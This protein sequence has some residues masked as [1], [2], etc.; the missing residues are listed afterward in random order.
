M[1][2]QRATNVGPS[3]IEIAYERLG[4]PAATPVLLIMGLG[5]QLIG[6]A[7]D[8]CNELVRRGL[9]VIRFDNR[10]VGESTHMH[11]APLP[12]L[13]AAMGGDYSTATYRLTDMAA[14]AVGLLDVLGIESA[15]VVGASMGG[16]I[17]QTMAIEH[18]Q[19]VRSL[20]SIMS[21]T[22][23]RTVG[24]MHPE[25]LAL[26][27][28]PPVV[29]RE[30]SVQRLIDIFKVIGSPGFTPDLD[31][32][33]ERAGRAFDRANDPLGMARQ[34]LAVLASGDRTERL[35]SVDVP[36]LVIH[37]E[38]DKMCDLSG[39]RATAEAIAGAELFIVDGMGHDMPRAMW[40]TFAD[41]ISAVIQRGEARRS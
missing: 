4:D 14:D 3:K 23:S 33:R 35:R 13:P 34:G 18:P 21:S 10:D 6:W 5:T 17:A 20:T 1:T 26:F 40:P 29:T 36:A 9:H 37:G 25:A 27:A 31:A 12:N 19:R 2:I 22:G 41:K 28:M 15:H 8:F 32:L 7:D 16:F 11:H 38:T 24:Q 39:G 30:Q